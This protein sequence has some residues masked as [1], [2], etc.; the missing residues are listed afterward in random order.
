[1]EKIQ[2]LSKDPN[3]NKSLLK[4]IRQEKHARRKS[5]VWIT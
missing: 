4:I 3:F 5:Q 2:Q 1:M